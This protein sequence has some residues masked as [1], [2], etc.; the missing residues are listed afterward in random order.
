M[1]LNE[2][3]LSDRKQFLF[4]LS[5]PLVSLRGSFLKQFY[6]ENRDIPKRILYASKAA[7]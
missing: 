5:E 2:L 3:G 7:G 1:R 4:E 6:S